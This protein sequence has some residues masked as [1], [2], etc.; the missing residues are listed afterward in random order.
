MDPRCS[1]C[2]FWQRVHPESDLGKCRRYPPH[3]PETETAMNLLPAPAVVH[4]WPYTL[5][6]N[7]CGEFAS[8]TIPYTYPLHHSVN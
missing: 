5:A 3:L 4:G 7:W 2:R 8:G 1:G 6:D